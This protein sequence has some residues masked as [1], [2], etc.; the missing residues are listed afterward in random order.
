LCSD[1]EVK[2]DE[3]IDEFSKYFEGKVTPKIIITTCLKPTK[4]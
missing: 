1:E 3:A 2:G 4:V